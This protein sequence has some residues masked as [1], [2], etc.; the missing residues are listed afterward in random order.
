M[1]KKIA[2]L[3]LIG[4]FQLTA[5]YANNEVSI[6]TT[7]DNTLIQ[8][9]DGSLGNSLGD[10]FVGR[11][12]QD[13]NGTATLSIRRGLVY[14]DIAGNVPA[15]ATIDSVRLYLNLTKSSSQTNSD[16]SL[17]KVLSNWGEGTSYYNGGQGAAAT[18]NDATWTYSFYNTAS[19]ATPG[20]DFEPTAS[21]VA[22]VAY[23]TPVEYSWSS[24]TM[25]AEVQAWL[26]TPS[27]NYGWL[28]QGD[29]STGKTVKQFSSKDTGTSGTYP[30][31]KVY[32][33][34]GAGIEN[35]STVSFS[36][37]PNPA[38]DFVQVRFS[39][40]SSE[41]ISI[42]SLTGTLLK[43]VTATNQNIVTINLSGITTGVYIL[44]AGNK[45]SRL[46]VK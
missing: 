45:T 46:L 18:T 25:K 11:T 41:T 20:G 31:L 16:I 27:A 33:S 3:G 29:E 8:T 39:Q 9:S 1:K 5:L 23:T 10:L 14:F 28:L 17:H 30:T 4:L 36:T 7:K 40:P 6:V 42:Y 15:N 32:Y 37:Y 38:T 19:W 26:T 44:K 12:N 34:S 2:T 35:A 24:E 43:T 13:A 22:T 21:A